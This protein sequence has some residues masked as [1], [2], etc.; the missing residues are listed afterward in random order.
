MAVSDVL[1]R[2]IATGVGVACVAALS[3]TAAMAAVPALKGRV[4]WSTPPPLSYVV[5]SAVDLNASLYDATPRTVFIFAR[6]SCG[7]CQRSKPQMAALVRELAAHN[8]T[9][10]VLVTPPNAVED[11]EFFAREIG[12]DSSRIARVAPASLRV[13]VV[14]TVVVVDRHGTVLLGKEGVLTEADRKDVVKS[15]TAVLDVE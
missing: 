5:G 11:T 15:T 10:V 6:S 8:D 13:R 1:V 12:L 9:C 7:A 3:L 2:R 14:P 4:G